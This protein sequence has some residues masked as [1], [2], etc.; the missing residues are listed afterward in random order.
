VSASDPSLIPC[1]GIELGQTALSAFAVRKKLAI[2]NWPLV[3]VALGFGPLA[4]IV[5]LIKG[6]GA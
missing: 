6:C 3:A 1:S 5:G 2:E 4:R